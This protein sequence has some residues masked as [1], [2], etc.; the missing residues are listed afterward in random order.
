M[1]AE[2][3]EI[4]ESFETSTVRRKTVKKSIKIEEVSNVF[5]EKND[6]VI[7]KA[8]D[9]VMRHLKDDLAVSQCAPSH[10]AC[11]DC[12]AF[13]RLSKTYLLRSISFF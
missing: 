4:E 10:K 2:I 13:I 3:E 9:F 1:E 7:Q 11:T 8:L 5:K 12:V 6:L